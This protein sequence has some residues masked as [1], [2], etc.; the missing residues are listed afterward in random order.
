MDI[1]FQVTETAVT[2]ILDGK[3]VSVSKGQPNY[4]PLVTALMTEDWDAVQSL[5]TVKAQVAAW[6][7]GAF[8]AQGSQI[9]YGEEVLPEALADQ[10][11]KALKEGASPDRYLRF[12]ERLALNP[13]HRSVSQL[14]AFL[15]HQNIGI[16]PAGTILAYKGITSDSKDQHTRSFDNT[17]GQVLQMDR[18]RVS[19]DPRQAC[20]FGFH[21]GAWGYA[22]TFSA[23]VVLCE[24]DPAD[25]VCVPY[26]HGEQKM[27][28]CRYK[29]LG[30]RPAP[31]TED[32]IEESDIPQVE[33]ENAVAIAGEVFYH[34]NSTPVEP[35]ETV[36]AKQQTTLVPVLTGDFA[37]L[38]YVAG[39]DL[40]LL[41]L[42][43]L[44]RYASQNLLIVGASKLPGGKATLIA[45]IFERRGYINFSDAPQRVRDAQPKD[46]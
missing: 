17:P 29:V 45:T 28:V 33:A 30:Y 44:R 22:S 38:N 12:W 11:L 7:D 14:F 40:I 26:D 23:Q 1:K 36:A 9:F 21:V 8:R 20:H 32:L 42:D 10:I 46:Q 43:A 2:V 35:G 34:P 41:P 24:V 13:S 3:P 25:V 19:D 37:Y 27:R 4:K 16:S 18:R 39:K 6:S 31:L 15:A 5:L